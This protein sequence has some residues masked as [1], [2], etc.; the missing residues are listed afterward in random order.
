MSVY[1]FYL[2]SITKHASDI[3]IVCEQ[4]SLE[5]TISHGQGY[6]EKEM[7]AKCIL[8]PQSNFRIP[9]QFKYSMLNSNNLAENKDK[10]QII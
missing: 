8:N 7:S 3:D 10:L 9:G 4:V 5:V 2:R 1:N 6:Y